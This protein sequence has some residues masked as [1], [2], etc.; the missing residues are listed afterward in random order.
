[1]DSTF[2]RIGIGRLSIPHGLRIAEVAGRQTLTWDMDAPW[3]VVERGDVALGAISDFRLLADEPTD[4]VVL[5]LAKTYGPLLLCSHGKP[6]LH[7]SDPVTPQA[8]PHLAAP[9]MRDLDRLESSDTVT[10]CGPVGLEPLTAWFR[11]ARRV[12]RFAGACRALPG[13]R[14]GDNGER[15]LE[16]GQYSALFQDLLGSDGE[17]ALNR[18]RRRILAIMDEWTRMSDLRVS[19]HWGGRGFEAH[20]EGQGALGAVVQDLV[21]TRGMPAGAY[22]TCSGCRTVFEVDSRRRRPAG[23]RHWCGDLDCMRLKNREEQ[24]RLRQRSQG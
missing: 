3:H 10:P 11:W 14:G 2:V 9:R 15:I 19:T 18:K 24:R 7:A 5:S 6:Y 4:R 23:K 13:M 1:M 21:F 16:R 22:A 8:P 20:L 12:K 17:P